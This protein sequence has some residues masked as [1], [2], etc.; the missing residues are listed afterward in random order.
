M[1]DIPDWRPQPRPSV[2]DLPALPPGGA[3][4]A[5]RLRSELSPVR[6]RIETALG[7]CSL[8]AQ[9]NPTFSGTLLEYL[10][11]GALPL[12][13][14]Q[15]G[16]GHCACDPRLIGSLAGTLGFALHS[17]ALSP[18]S[19]PF[20]IS[21]AGEFLAHAHWEITT[22]SLELRLPGRGTSRL[23]LRGRISSEHSGLGRIRFDA[24]GLH[25]ARNLDLQFDLRERESGMP[26]V[27]RVLGQIA[28]EMEYPADWRPRGRSSGFAV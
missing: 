28:G 7:R 6:I 8:A 3:C 12:A 17:F 27:L 2:A 22:G 15:D 10:R 11:P 25:I 23:D 1:F 9:Q 4:C 13:L 24:D 19:R 20:G 21:A 18:R 16:G 14:G 26:V 5:F